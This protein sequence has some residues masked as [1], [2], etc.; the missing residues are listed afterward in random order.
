[1]LV[2]GILPASDWMWVRMWEIWGMGKLSVTAV[3]AATRPGRIGDGDGL[4][5]VVQPGGTK[6][7]IC[8]VQKNGTRRDFGL[9]STTKVSL[10]LARERAREIRTW[11]EMGLDPLFERHKARGI[12]TFKDAAAKV[13]AAHRKT[14]RNEKHEGQWQRTLEA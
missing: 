9:G 11:M 2:L 4:F 14:W 5:L 13:L 3:K 12:P 7:W 8:R 10:A 6:S 1:M